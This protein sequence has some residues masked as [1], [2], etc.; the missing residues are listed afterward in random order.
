MLKLLNVVVAG[1]NSMWYLGPGLLVLWQGLHPHTKL[2]YYRNK[3]GFTADFP[4]SMWWKKKRWT[5][6]GLI[7]FVHAAL[8]CDSAARSDLGEFC[9][10]SC[11]APCC[12]PWVSCVFDL[13]PRQDSR[14]LVWK[15]KFFY[16]PHFT[17]LNS[18]KGIKPGSTISS[19][20]SCCTEKLL[21]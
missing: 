8:S 10:V 3:T 11:C 5:E 15:I 1:C 6:I 2:K 19:T 13:A 14:W 17:S 9:G 7:S 12:F 4:W 16:G 20:R 21:K 18:K